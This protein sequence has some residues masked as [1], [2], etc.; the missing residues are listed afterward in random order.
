MPVLAEQLLVIL[1]AFVD[2]WLAGVYLESPHLAAIGFIWYALWAV[3]TMFSII[4]TGATALTARFVGA[5]QWEDARHV[6]NQALLSGAAFAAVVMVMMVFLGDP[7]LSWMQLDDEAARLAAQYLWIILPIVPAIMIEEVGLACLRGAGDTASGLLVRLIVNVINLTL[8]VTLVTG[9]GIA[10]KL[11]WI[12]LAIASAT[13]YGVGAV[14]VLVMLWRG[15]GGLNLS[16]R[17]LRLD[18]HMQRRILRIGIPGGGDAIATVAIHLWFLSIINSLGT[19]P[20][21]AHGLAVRIEALSYLPGAAFMVAASTLTG[22][23]LG[24]RDPRRA[25]HSAL[26]CLAWGGGIMVAASAAMY[27]WADPLTQFFLGDQNQQVAIEAAPLLRIVAMSIPGFA[28]LMV[29]SGAL[30]GAG[31]TRLPLLITFSGL[32]LV[33]IPLAYFMATEEGIP[34]TNWSGWNWGVQ[35]AWYA[36]LV[37]VMLRGGFTLA[38]FIQGGWQKIHV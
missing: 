29:L 3:P 10:P 34:G 15:R 36:M 5:K 30:R 13:G 6:V 37:D 27:I 28:V 17:H 21:A 31:D 11:G 7:F 9:W 25:V 12:G 38:R 23:S 1:V 33:R 8:G 4:A 32:L 16:R 19:L 2:Q 26:L 20:A 18:V 14:I 22:Q 35:G 24:A